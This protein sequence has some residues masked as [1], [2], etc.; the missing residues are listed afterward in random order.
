MTIQA[1]FISTKTHKPEKT[2]KPEPLITF[3]KVN[4]LLLYFQS[5]KDWEPKKEQKISEK[6][7]PEY[8]K[9]FANF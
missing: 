1:P 9:W 7:I 2:I 5:H 6:D 3:M 8:E 4:Y